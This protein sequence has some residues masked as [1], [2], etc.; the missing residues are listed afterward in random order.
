MT[1]PVSQWE[2]SGSECEDYTGQFLLYLLPPPPHLSMCEVWAGAQRVL[3]I[4]HTATLNLKFTREQRTATRALSEIGTLR[5]LYRRCGARLKTESK[6]LVASGW[7]QTL[8][9][10][11]IWTAHHRRVRPRVE[12]AGTDRL[13]PNPRNPTHIW[14]AHHRA[15]ALIS[16]TMVARVETAGTD[17]L[18]PSPWKTRHILWWSPH[19]PTPRLGSPSTGL[20]RSLR[21]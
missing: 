4:A 13:Q 10:W 18:E 11:H 1:T 20:L 7:N 19:C 17:R 12:I 2:V 14:T 6:S 21:P 15:P 16:Q 8:W 9:T 3:L 5:P